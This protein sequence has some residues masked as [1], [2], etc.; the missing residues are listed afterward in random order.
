[1][2]LQNCSVMN[3]G[4]GGVL[5]EVTIEV[6]IDDHQYPTIWVFKACTVNGH[7]QWQS[8]KPQ[9]AAVLRSMLQSFSGI[10]LWECVGP[11][12]HQ[13]APLKEKALEKYAKWF[14]RLNVANS[15]G[16]LISATETEAM[17]NRHTDTGRNK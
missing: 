11:S 5:N 3:R 10:V 7:Q 15:Q 6:T 12:Q 13:G 14:E 1:M 16:S 8:D 9:T 4:L 17:I 2:Q